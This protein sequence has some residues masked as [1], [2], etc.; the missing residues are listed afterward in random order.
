V[1]ETG[2]PSDHGPLKVIAKRRQKKVLCRTSGNRSQV[3]LI[4]C[5]SATGHAIP[6]YMTFDAKKNYEWIKADVPGT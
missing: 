1:D 2:M 5:V 4:A 3:T 6:P